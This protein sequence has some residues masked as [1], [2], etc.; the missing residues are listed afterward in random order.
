MAPRPGRGDP[1]AARGA[2]ADRGPAG[3]PV[4]QPQ[5]PAAR[6]RGG[7]QGV[8]V[9][10]GRGHGR[11]RRSR[12]RGGAARAGPQGTP[13][14]GPALLDG[15]PGRVLVHPRADPRGL[16][17]PDPAG[18]P[19][20][21]APARRGLDRGHRRAAGRRP[22]RDLAAHYTTVLDLARAAKDPRAGELAASAVH[23]LMLA[24]DRAVGID[25]AAAERHYANALQLSSDT[26]RLHAELLVRHGEALRQRGRFPEAVPAYEQAIELFRARGDA[27]SVAQA[28]TGYGMTLQG[29][30]DPRE[31]TLPTDALALA[32]PL[33]PSP[34]LVQALASEAGRR[35]MWGDH[36]EAIE[37]ADRALALAA[38]FGLPEPARALGF[39]GMA[40]VNLGDA[41][42]L[43]DMRKRSLRPPRRAS[44][45]TWLL[46]TTT[47]RRLHGGSRDP[48][49]AWSWLARDR[50]LP[51][52]GDRGGGALPRHGRRAGPDRFGVP[53]GSPGPGGRA[54][55][56]AGRDRQSI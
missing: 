11:T 36:Q 31:R 38:Q 32:E 19:R 20:E 45:A 7:G 8:L 26:G 56:A 43:E 15:R 17:R 25:V 29:L 46:S 1:A 18:R 34:E 28:M 24:G 50:A 37:H 53:G 42:G 3:H 35:T 4:R 49:S 54:G 40:R 51:G 10:R 22:R 27:I 47:W 12:G 9:R 2:R 5:T 16:L 52:A 21:A 39:R 55:P 33:G 41:G 23:Y 30:G 48:G 44:G 6:C 14:P 13:P